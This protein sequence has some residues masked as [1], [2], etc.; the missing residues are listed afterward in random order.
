MEI[1][2]PYNSPGNSIRIKYFYIFTY[3]EASQLRLM[4][5][6]QSS[7]DLAGASHR[8]WLKMMLQLHVYVSCRLHICSFDI[9]NAD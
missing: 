5:L 2:H 1:Y 3:S 6:S 8:K 9:I 7:A 4:R